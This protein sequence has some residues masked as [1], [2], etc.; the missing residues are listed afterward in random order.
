MTLWHVN[1]IFAREKRLGR[2]F[3]HNIFG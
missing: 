1:Q 2:D 3:I